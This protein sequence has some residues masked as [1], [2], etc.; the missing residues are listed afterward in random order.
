VRFASAGKKGTLV[1]LNG[2]VLTDIDL[3]VLLASHRRR[4]ALSTILL[5]EVEDPTVYG[6]VETGP[7]GRVRGFLEKPSWEEVKSNAVNAGIYVIEPELLDYMP[8]GVSSIERDFFPRLVRNREPFYAHTHRG[9]WLDI[10]TSGKYLQAHRDLLNKLKTD[11]SGY[12]KAGPGLWMAP[13]AKLKTSVQTRGTVMLG[14]RAEVRE[15]SQLTGCVVIGPGCR[16]G[17]HSLLED[18]VLWDEVEIGDRAKLRGCIL[19][20]G[21]Q[22]GAHAHLSGHVVLG[23]RAAV[24]AYSQVRGE[25]SK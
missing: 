13:R 5:T 20:R 21:V 25:D 16:I 12:R 10:G 2:D 3:R 14:P 15:S 24:P 11:Y 4:R 7:E 6:V 19:G 1:I 18:C 9:Y 22:V 23:D 8:Q 17:E